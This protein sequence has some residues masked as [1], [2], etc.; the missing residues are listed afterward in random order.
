MRTK[1]I[2]YLDTGQNTYLRRHDIYNTGARWDGKAK[3]WWADRP[4]PIRKAAEMVGGTPV[5]AHVQTLPKVS[6]THR[7]GRPRAGRK[8]A[9]TL[10]KTV[11]LEV[12]HSSNGDGK[13]RPQPLVATGQP[14][15]RGRVGEDRRKME[16]RRNE[17]TRPEAVLVVPMAVSEPGIPGIPPKP[18]LQEA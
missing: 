7:G 8:Q 4:G 3:R 9:P 17:G 11:A 10:T 15:V 14:F 5:A 1:K 6:K 16:D 18:H 2:F 12:E 13:E